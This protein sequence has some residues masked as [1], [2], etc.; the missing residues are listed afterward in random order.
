MAEYKPSF[1][2]TTPIDLLIPSYTESKGAKIKTFPAVG[3]RLNCSFKTY[4]GTETSTNGVFS[5]IDTAIVETW[6][7]PDI[8]S[9]CRIRLFSSGQVYEIIGKPENINERNQFI[10]FKVRAVEGGA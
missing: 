3:I 9:D 7:R 10:R 2:F 8:K 5:V 4:G 1:P 6:Y